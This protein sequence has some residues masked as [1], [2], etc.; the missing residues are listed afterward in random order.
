MLTT[1]PI[2]VFDTLSLYDQLDQLVKLVHPELS[3][4]SEMEAM[5]APTQLFA[6]RKVGRFLASAS[7]AT[8][9]PAHPCKPKA[10]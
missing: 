4:Q 8:D 5:Y 10:T 1:Q 7:A 2:I 3:I 6:R 9:L